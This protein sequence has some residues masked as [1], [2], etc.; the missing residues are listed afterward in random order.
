MAAVGL[1]AGAAE[2]RLARAGASAAR[3]VV[4]CDNSPVS[5]TLG[6]AI[7]CLVRQGTHE[8]SACLGARCK[9]SLQ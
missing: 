9:R 3:C 1:G 6:G 4:A 2:A 8:T 5:T 7:R